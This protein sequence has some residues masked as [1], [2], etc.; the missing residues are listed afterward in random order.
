[1]GLSI[2]SL[3]ALEEALRRSVTSADQLI[4]GTHRYFS[5]GASWYLAEV[6]RRG[7]GGRWDEGARYP[8]LR[9]VGPFHDGVIPV[10]ELR[11]AVTE[12]GHLRGCYSEYS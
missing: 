10:I 3:D 8:D 7:L 12:A 4:D 9:Q 6:L 5:D 2:A 11:R 1:V